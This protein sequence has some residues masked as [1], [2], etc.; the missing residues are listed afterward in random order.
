MSL[1][2]DTK[3]PAWSKDLDYTPTSD[4]IPQ[5]YASKWN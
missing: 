5:L 4:E 3:Y 1:F 2:T